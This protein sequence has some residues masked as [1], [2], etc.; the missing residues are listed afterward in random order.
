MWRL[1][2][3]SFDYWSMTPQNDVIL[4]DLQEYVVSLNNKATETNLLVSFIG[5]TYR[6][7]LVGF[8]GALFQFVLATAC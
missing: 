2:T 6:K 3:R 4:R 5:L 8:K 7:F 1:N